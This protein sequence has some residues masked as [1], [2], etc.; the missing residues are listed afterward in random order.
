[1]AVAE[2]MTPMGQSFMSMP[3]PCPERGQNIAQVIGSYMKL[4]RSLRLRDQAGRREDLV[5]AVG[6]DLQ[7]FAGRNARG[8]AA[9]RSAPVEV[10]AQY[11]KWSRVGRPVAIPVS[12][13]S[14]T[15][16]SS[17]AAATDR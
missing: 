14:S 9:V 11:A 2:I 16:D 6:V 1:M 12:S 7:N 15:D 17:D 4:P 8:H 10:P 3:P 5:G 13:G